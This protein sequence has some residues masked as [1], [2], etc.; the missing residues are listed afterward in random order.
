MSALEY[1]HSTL[2]TNSRRCA[3]LQRHAYPQTSDAP[4]QT[5]EKHSYQSHH[6]VAQVDSFP[7]ALADSDRTDEKF[8]VHSDPIILEPDEKQNSGVA[9]QRAGGRGTSKMGSLKAKVLLA[10]VSLILIGVAMGVAMGI[11]VD[12]NHESGKEPSTT[13]SSITHSTSPASAKL[14]AIREKYD[15]PGLAVGHLAGGELI[16]E[17]VGVRKQDNPTLL[18]S[19]DV[20][21]LGGCTFP[22]TA[23]LVAVYIEEGLFNW[24]TTMTEV[25]TSSKLHEKHRQTTIG[26]LCSN[27]AGIFTTDSANAFGSWWTEFR[28]ESTNPVDLRWR[29]AQET[30]AKAPVT[31]P[32]FA[33]NLSVPGYMILASILEAKTGRSWESLMQDF[34]TL[35]DMDGCG[36]GV[37]PESSRSAV[38]NPWPHEAS[39]SGPVPQLPDAVHGDN[40]SAL[41]PAVGVHCSMSSY[42]SFLQLHLDG[43][44][45]RPTPFLKK[46]SFQMLHTPWPG[47]A[48]GYTYGGWT[49][50]PTFA[51]GTEYYVSGTNT[52]N[53]ARGWLL[54]ERDEAFMSMTNEGGEDGSD[55]SLAA[56]Y[57][58]AGYNVAP[59]NTY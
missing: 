58:F 15:V 9:P 8:V 7:K 26:M 51:N 29:F 2:E 33:W 48:Q 47:L 39:A 56:L 27:T 41:W 35:L 24:N 30:L 43:Y 54:V 3:K 20:F 13:G 38:D 1:S 4:G 31:D 37:Q 42:A 40:P 45:G 21:H 44:N 59:S 17:V 32:G 11:T 57:Y 5:D 49:Y 36:F 18:Q 55:A 6:I 14:S 19:N 53:Y 28:N 34:F 10:V 50:D 16:S 23:T 46:E 52:F 12:R 22:L 25:F